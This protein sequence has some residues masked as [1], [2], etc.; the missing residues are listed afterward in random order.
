[1]RSPWGWTPK[2]TL[3]TLFSHTDFSNVPKSAGIF[4]ILNIGS[5]VMFGTGVVEKLGDGSKE[6]DVGHRDLRNRGDSEWSPSL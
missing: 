5:A 2:T 1:M 4:I 3:D 6:V